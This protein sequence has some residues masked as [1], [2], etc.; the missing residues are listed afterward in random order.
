MKFLKENRGIIIV[1]L[2]IIILFVIYDIWSK[3]TGKN[4]FSGKDVL[5]GKYIIEVP[6]DVRDMV[7]ELGFNTTMKNGRM[8]EFDKLPVMLV[9]KD[10]ISRF[11]KRKF[12]L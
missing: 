2:I 8:E 11:G 7:S 9:L 3:K 1:L 6:K 12:F 10:D 4:F 5:P